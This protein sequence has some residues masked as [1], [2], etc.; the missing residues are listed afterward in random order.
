MLDIEGQ[1]VRRSMHMAY[2]HQSSIVHLLGRNS[3]AARLPVGPSR[4]AAELDQVLRR[5]MQHLAA[6]VQ[7]DH[8]PRGNRVKEIRTVRQPSQ[9]ACIDEIGHYS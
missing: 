9:D 2:C 3:V 8:G 4:H 5:E 1:Q 7:L 6:A